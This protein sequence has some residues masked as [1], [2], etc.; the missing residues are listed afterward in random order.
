MRS[1]DVRPLPLA[2]VISVSAMV[3]SCV[4]LVYAWRV[5]HRG[6]AVAFGLLLAGVVGN[7]TDRLFRVPGPFRGHVVDFLALPHWP[8]FNVAVVC[9]DAAGALIV[10]LLLRGVGL[11]GTREGTRDGTRDE[12]STR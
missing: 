5:R 9:I 4:V 1:I 2:P 8:I 3:A 10:V 11:D 12:E 7:L 6:W